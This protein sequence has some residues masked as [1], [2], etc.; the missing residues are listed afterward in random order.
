MGRVPWVQRFRRVKGDRWRGWLIVNGRRIYGPMRDTA[1]AAHRDAVKLREERAKMPD[2]VLTFGEA[3]DA[4]RVDLREAG[5]RAGTRERFES[6]VRALAQ[7]WPDAYPI[8]RVS[9]DDICAFIAER[10]EGD[11]VSVGTVRHNLR[12]LRRILRHAKR[13]GA[14]T[15]NPLD[16]VRIPGEPEEAI[17]YYDP[18]EVGRIIE[19]IRAQDGATAQRDADLVAFLFRTGLR[20][21]ECGRLRTRDIDLRAGFVRVDGKCGLRSVPIHPAITAT[22]TARA[23]SRLPAA[24]LWCPPNGVTCAFTRWA[25]V[26]PA[27]LRDRFRPHTLRHSFATALVRAGVQPLQVARL[28][29]HATVQMTARYYHAG[30]PELR[31]AIARLP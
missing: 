30:D 22:V 28:M 17:D 13:L 12:A 11:G 6:Q 5:R 29:G 8:L 24:L 7:C 9:P 20:R 18:D 31:H 23:A 25:G 2:R 3:V 26:L 19:A 4:V 14:L 27:E 21:G 15:D 1:Q 10:R 16:Q